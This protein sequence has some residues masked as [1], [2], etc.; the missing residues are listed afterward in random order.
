MGTLG[1]LYLFDLSMGTGWLGA[2]GNKLE[3]T[4][5]DLEVQHPASLGIIKK[6]FSSQ[7]FYQA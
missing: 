2:W 1:N 3:L 5:A 7:I 4:K 6:S